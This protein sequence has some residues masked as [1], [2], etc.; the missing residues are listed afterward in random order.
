MLTLFGIGPRNPAGGGSHSGLMMSHAN[1]LD[2]SSGIVPLGACA[3][4]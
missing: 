1:V 2:A 4:A 3:E